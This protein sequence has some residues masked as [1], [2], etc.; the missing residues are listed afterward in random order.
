MILTQ[1]APAAT[2]PAQPAQMGTRSAPHQWLPSSPAR[3]PVAS[4]AQSDAAWLWRCVEVA[5]H[6][7]YSA[8]SAQHIGCGARHHADAYRVPTRA[9]GV[10]HVTYT[11]DDSSA[12]ISYAHDGAWRCQ[13]PA[14]AV[15]VPCQHVGAAY[16][17]ACRR[18]EARTAQRQAVMAQARATQA[19]MT[20]LDERLSAMKHECIQRA[21]VASLGW[22]APDVR[23]MDEA[24]RYFELRY[25]A[26]ASQMAQFISSATTALYH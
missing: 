5:H 13:C 12:Y 1:V 4:G 9:G 16:L 2:Q 11:P 23:R 26:L 24:I 18:D 20:A 14:G 8:H 15:G 22:G 6:S 7:G 25:R 19:Q 17:L 21:Q 10:Y 3:L